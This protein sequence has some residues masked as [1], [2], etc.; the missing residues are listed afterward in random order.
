MLKL[1]V[2]LPCYNEAANLPELIEAYRLAMAG[3]DHAEL[4]LVDNGSTDN[5]AK[6]LAM[7]QRKHNPF[8]L[9]IVTVEGNKGYG[10]GIM[11]GL[12]EAG[13]EYLAWSHSDL[14]C[15]PDDVIRLY[16]AV[17]QRPEPRRCFGKGF[18]ISRRGAPAI[19]TRLQAI[20][21]RIILGYDLSE[22]NAQPKLFHRDF[23][24]EFRVPP[25]GFEL[26]IYAYFKAAR[27]NMD[28]VNID[29]HFHKRKAGE[30]K[31][32]YSFLSRLSF[33]I[34]NFFY[35]LKLRIMGDRI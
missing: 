13:G 7:E 29:V 19:F 33:M 5:T 21:S 12:S 28:V 6:V 34:E 25:A 17:I 4:I 26:D 2:V 31:W 27:K 1:S 11:K 3:L 9:K 10:D 23:I 32:A 8:A 30:S 15:S 20:L 35:L 18:R 24:R 16:D 14:Q 22:I